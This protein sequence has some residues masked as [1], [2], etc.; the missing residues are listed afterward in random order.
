MNNRAIQLYKDAYAVAVNTVGKGH[1]D[2]AYFQGVVT[3]K[4]AELIV[5]ECA[6]LFANDLHSMRDYTGKACRYMI[7]EH[8]GITE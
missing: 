7:K 8:F 6:D 4:F 5:K 1:A 3:G 2:T